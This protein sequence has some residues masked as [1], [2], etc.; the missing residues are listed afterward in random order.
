MKL[1]RDPF[2]NELYR[3]CIMRLGSDENIQDS[4]EALISSKPSFDYL[5]LDFSRSRCFENLSQELRDRINT[6]AYHNTQWID[7]R[8]CMVSNIDPSNTR[9]ISLADIPS[10][11]RDFIELSIR[12]FKVLYIPRI[13]RA[14]SISNSNSDIIII[15]ES[16][17]LNIPSSWKSMQ[18]S[19]ED[20]NG[21]QKCLVRNDKTGYQDSDDWVSMHPDIG[22]IIINFPDLRLDL[23][24]Q[25]YGGLTRTN[26]N[27]RLRKF[28]QPGTIHG[29]RPHKTPLSAV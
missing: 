28:R 23:M 17:R 16:N 29:S 10:T 12:G 2:S 20:E 25:H 7:N 5:L 22:L 1:R 9:H 19:I 21:G 8:Y 14:E 18:Y 6:W 3:F 13:L 24:R 27:Q 4:V 26:T 11:N 15:S